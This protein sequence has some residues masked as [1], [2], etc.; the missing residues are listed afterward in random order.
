MWLKTI[1]NV[2]A[3]EGIKFKREKVNTWYKESIK[4]V[5][6]NKL[7]NPKEEYWQK[8]RISNTRINPEKANRTTRNSKYFSIISLNVNC[9]NSPTKSLK[10]SYCIKIARSNLLFTLHKQRYT[11]RFKA[12]KCKMK[13][14]VNRSW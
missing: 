6:L 13:F 9:F 8:K 5:Q 4:H 14:Q 12:K 2:R 7:A 10:L 3:L 11:H 1:T